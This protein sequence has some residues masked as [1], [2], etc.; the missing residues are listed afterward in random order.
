MSELADRL[1]AARAEVARLEQEFRQGPCREV[2]HTW[3]FLGGANAGCSDT[4]GCSVSVHVCEKCGDCD[5]G[6]NEEAVQIRKD[7]EERNG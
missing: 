7:C 6:D 1:E 3:K 2:G 5:Y 4:C